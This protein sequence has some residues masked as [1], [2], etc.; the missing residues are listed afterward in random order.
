MKKIV[1]ALVGQ[2]NV[3]KS[4]LANA[5]SGSNLK[6]GNFAGV[7]VEK[8]TARLS[9]EDFSIE[10][11][12]LPGLYS[13][14]DFSADEKVTKDFLLKGEYDLILNVIDSTNLERNLMLTTELMELQKKMV[15]ALN[16]DDEAIKEGINIDS[17]AMSKILSLPCIRV[18]SK[19]KTKMHPQKSK[20]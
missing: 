2:P 16:M 15:I 7:T 20:N 9:T 1:I 12:D 17:D 19:L 18:S 10:F 4:H 5:I 11:I 6:I 14:E 8:A 3:G 13:L